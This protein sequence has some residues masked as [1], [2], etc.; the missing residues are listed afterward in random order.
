MPEQRARLLLAN[1]LDDLE[2]NSVLE[3]GRGK[4]EILEQARVEAEAV[5]REGLLRVGNSGGVGIDG[6]H[7]GPHRCHPIGE[8]PRP[9]ADVEHPI[10]RRGHEEPV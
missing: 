3:A 5:P 8:N 4:I 7:H 1:V 2:A 6:G 9:T 10:V